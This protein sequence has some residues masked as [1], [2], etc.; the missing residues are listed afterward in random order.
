MSIST[1]RSFLTYKLANPELLLVHFAIGI[2]GAC[3]PLP[4]PLLALP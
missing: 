3:L 2:A 1:D 4:L